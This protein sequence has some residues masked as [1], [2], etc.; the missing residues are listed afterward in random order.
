MVAGGSCLLGL[1]MDLVAVF[2]RGREE[3]TRS[4]VPDFL[5]MRILSDQVPHLGFVLTSLTSLIQQTATLGV[6]LQHMNER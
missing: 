6:G 4:L 5:K 2:S 1:Q 3:G